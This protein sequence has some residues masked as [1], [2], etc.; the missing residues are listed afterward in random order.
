MNHSTPSI[1]AAATISSAAYPKLTGKVEFR[2]LSDGVLVTADIWGLPPSP[3][4]FFALHIHE[5]T[6]CGGEK[7]AASGAHFNPAKLPHPLH[8]GDLPPLLSCNGHAYLSVLTDR[9][10]LDDVIGRTVIIHD[11]TDDF[12]SQPSGDAGTK[13]ACGIIRPLR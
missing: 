4:D 6:D 3:T 13:I 9:F 2:R 11:G 10:H 7:Y 12:R 8:A 1:I 5:G